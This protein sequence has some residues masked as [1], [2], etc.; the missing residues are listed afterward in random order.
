MS[1]KHVAKS[2]V[3]V[4]VT[5]FWKRCFCSTA[6]QTNFGATD[7]MTVIFGAWREVQT[8]GCAGRF[9]QISAIENARCG[10]L[11]RA[12]TTRTPSRFGLQIQFYGAFV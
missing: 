1:Q 7:S 2:A 5:N 6:P 4:D 9:R 3:R 12:P 10:E 11:P 8:G